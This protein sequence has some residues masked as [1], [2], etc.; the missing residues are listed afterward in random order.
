MLRG[1]QLE[2]ELPDGTVLDAPD[3]AD[4][5]T[6]VQNYQRRSAAKSTWDAMAPD[7]KAPWRPYQGVSMDQM[8]VGMAKPF[9]ETGLGIKDLAGKVGIGG[10]LTDEDKA[11]L[12]RLDV[13]KSPSATLGNM[14]S[15]LATLA[16]PGKA[17]QELVS[18]FPRAL[19]YGRAAMDM[20]TSAGMEGL[21]APR[22]ET[23][24]GERAGWGAFGAL[25]GHTVAGVAG[26]AING[27][28]NA[29]KPAREMLDAGIPL[30]PGMMAGGVLQAAE[31]KLSTVPFLGAP[32]RARQRAA[33][34][35]WNKH[36]LNR[37]IPE[38]TATAAGHEGMKQVTDAF[39]QSYEKLWAND[40]P[41]DLRKMYT[42]WDALVANSKRTLP[43]QAA[44]EVHEELARL[45]QD[46]ISTTRSGKAIPGQTV[47]QLDDVLRER[48][49]D[50]M[51]DG[52][53]TTAAI[54]SI[55]RNRMR[56]QLPPEMSAELSRVD[57]LYSQ[58]AVLRRAGASTA[59]QRAGGAITPASVLT[60]SRGLDRTAGK[61][62]TARGQ[63]VLQPQATQAANV[64]GNAQR[65][66]D[67]L[68]GVA[69][70]PL[71]ATSALTH[72]APV[73]ALLTGQ[74]APQ[75]A[76]RQIAMDPKMRALI[77]ALRTRTGPGQIGTAAEQQ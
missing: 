50:A 3:G 40:V 29:T 13:A 64:I 46:V 65:P 17:G 49:T 25:A 21:K 44:N 39:T 30:T 2:I 20:L 57:Q 72:N 38:G 56:A 23:S 22:D 47:S 63:G 42:D 5:K 51:R 12:E 27:V 58:Y 33:I 34:E 35:A 19:K 41:F 55:A 67:F 24:R 31:Q 10:G 61:G 53:T 52:D 15:E 59:A 18:K 76:M 26:R 45:F 36:M 71:A 37:V 62:A 7:M 9:V 54:Y 6:V 4:V 68:S 32:I 1:I 70:A 73:N 66:P 28:V 48:Y 77:D 60:A 11:N 8:R 14:T 43:K 16:L 75:R 69:M 74:T